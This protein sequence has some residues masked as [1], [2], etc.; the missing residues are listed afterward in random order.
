MGGR[1][2]RALGRRGPGR[3]ALVPAVLAAVLAAATGCGPA[4]PAAGAQPAAASGP[5][6][7]VRVLQMTCATA[8][9]PAATPAGRWPR[10]RR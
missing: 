7:A 10:A 6:T 1:P 2:D 8:A 5:V 3:R 4:T 9:S